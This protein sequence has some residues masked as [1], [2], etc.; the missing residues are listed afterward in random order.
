MNETLLPEIYLG[1]IACLQVPWG[2]NHHSCSILDKAVI[3]AQL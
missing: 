1:Y 3:E 2:N